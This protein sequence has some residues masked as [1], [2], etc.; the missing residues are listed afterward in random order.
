LTSST[1]VEG[2]VTITNLH[3]RISR[4]FHTSYAR[5]LS[6][7]FESRSHGNSQI[8]HSRKRGCAADDRDFLLLC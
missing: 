7:S 8:R 6:L 5:F 2:T 1:G 4:G 3:A